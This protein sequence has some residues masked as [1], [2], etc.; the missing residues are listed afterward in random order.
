[1]EVISITENE[2]GSADVLLEV[3]KEEND[4]FVEYAIVDI[5]K[6]K[7]EEVLNENK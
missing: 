7:C 3:T 4:I 6:K 1:M 5:L 2:D